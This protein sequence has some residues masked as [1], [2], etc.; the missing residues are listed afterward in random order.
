MEY[1]FM[2]YSAKVKGSDVLT[3]VSEIDLRSLTEAR[4]DTDTYLSIYTSANRDARLFV[5]SRLKAI[6]RALPK[7]LEDHFDKA[8]QM[9]EPALVSEPA[10]GERGCVI[11]A[12]AAKGFLRIYRLS[13]ELEPIVVWDRSPFVLPLAR[14]RRD[15]ED[16]GLLLLDSQE[17]RLFLVRSD[18]IEEKEKASIDLM[19]RHKKGGWSQMR[20]NRLR[21]GA[22][23]SFLS[24]LIDDLQG[25]E[26]L[27]KVKGL[28]IA[29]Q[30]EARSQFMEML[31]P[32]LKSRVLD[33]VNLS[34]KTPRGDLVRL[35]DEVVR[36]KRS[37]ERALAEELKDAVLKGQPAAYGL[38]E[39]KEA[40]EEGRVNHLLISEGFALPGMICVSCHHVHS[41][42]DRCPTCGGEMAAL[43]L[44]EIYEMAERTGADVVLVEDEFLESIG[45]VGATLRY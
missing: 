28:V 26:E 30:S 35:G 38:K 24:Q 17:A 4:D 41:E 16:Y 1:N 21:R 11:F 2:A 33:E 22:I 31:P 36:S 15:Y 34:I 25:W 7:D 3:P 14:L 27:P 23:K 18:V 5:A 43:K 44:E 40:L 39:V 12:S 45:H 32:S 8:L 37:K 9:A 20:F 19:N 29:G 10:K 6:R 42:G 13:V